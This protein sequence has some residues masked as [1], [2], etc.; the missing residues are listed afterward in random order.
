M[1]KWYKYLIP[2]C[3]VL[4]TTFV[5]AKVTLP[6][7]FSD[8]MVLQRDMPIHF[9]GW[10]DSNESVIITFNGLTEK[11]KTGKN[12]KWSLQ[13]P[14]MHYGGP[15]TITVKGK[16][17]T[18]AFENVL[19]GDIWLCSGQSNMEVPLVETNNSKEEIKG[20]ENKNIRLLKVP[21]TMQTHENEDIQ[22]ASWRECNP[23]SCAYFSAVAYF[24]GKNLQKNWTSQSELLRIAL[25]E[26]I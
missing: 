12:G 26:P 18:F 4:A 17:N 9:W 25:V 5:Q 19:I 11:V 22:K 21:R 13:F 6:Q 8:N 15:Y 1:S 20:S 3:L 10:A 23:V 16:E 24:V 2:V 14:A 7:F